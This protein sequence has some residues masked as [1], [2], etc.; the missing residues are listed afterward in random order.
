MTAVSG[1]AAD[2]VRDFTT[3]VGREVVTALHGL[4]RPAG[5]AA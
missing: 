2:L 3:P 5:S 4:L 1:F